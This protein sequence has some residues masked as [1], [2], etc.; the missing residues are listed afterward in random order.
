M[1]RESQAVGSPAEE[2]MHHR[3]AM[4]TNPSL[5]FPRSS[6]GSLLSFKTTGEADDPDTICAEW[7]YGNGDEALQSR[8]LQWQKM[9]VT[10]ARVRN[11]IR[12]T[13]RR[14]LVSIIAP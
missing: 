13:K 7:N 6:A 14:V 3:V 10:F 4:K 8:E 9:N 12:R 11:G 2:T 5:Y 1:R